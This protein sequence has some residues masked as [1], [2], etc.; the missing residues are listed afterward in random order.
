MGSFRRE[1]TFADREDFLGRLRTKL[2]HLRANV[3][4]GMTEAWEKQSGI[5]LA[6]IAG[7]GASMN[8]RVAEGSWRC[9]AELPDW[10][11]IPQR[12]IEQKFDEEFADLLKNQNGGGASCQ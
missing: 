6:R 11:P 10:L 8:F 7:Y 4:T 1:G 12:V 2:A 3:L 9:D 5:D